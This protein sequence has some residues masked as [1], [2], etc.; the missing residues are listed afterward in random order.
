MGQL[1]L[2]KQIRTGRREDLNHTSHY[3]LTGKGLPKIARK[4]RDE[5]IKYVIVSTGMPSLFKN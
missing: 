2:L 3:H 4:S 1:L 5:N